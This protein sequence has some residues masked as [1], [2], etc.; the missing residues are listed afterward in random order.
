MIFL[1]IFS[2][3]C[4]IDVIDFSG[5]SEAMFTEAREFLSCQGCDYLIFP[6][7]SVMATKRSI[8]CSSCSEGLSL[9]V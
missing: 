7:E 3:A 5:Y 6:G 4:V 1:G 2:L 9:P 8:L